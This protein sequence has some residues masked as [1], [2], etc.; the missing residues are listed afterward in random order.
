MKRSLIVFLLISGLCAPMGFT[1]DGVGEA[2]GDGVAISDNVLETPA[3]ELTYEELKSENE[4]L[5]KELT[6]L[7]EFALFYKKFY[8]NV[9]NA[10][11]LSIGLMDR[12]S[13]N[14]F[15]VNLVGEVLKQA[16]VQFQ[17]LVKKWNPEQS[18]K[19]TSGEK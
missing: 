5:R 10:V 9:V 17:A 4:S 15:Q 16:N 14:Q 19:E 3:K 1:N 13:V 7:N 2:L 8:E 18:E 12:E 11:N 6:K